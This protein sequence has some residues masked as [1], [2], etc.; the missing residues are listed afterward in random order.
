MS[1]L[2]HHE[3]HTEQPRTQRVIFHRTHTS[4]VFTVDSAISL[5]KKNRHKHLNIKLKIVV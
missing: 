5:Q 1:L 3:V 2:V 4:Q